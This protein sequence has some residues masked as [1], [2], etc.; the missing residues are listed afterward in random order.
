MRDTRTTPD[1][2]GG[3]SEFDETAFRADTI[4]HFPRTG[5]VDASAG[6]SVDEAPATDD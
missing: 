6:T 1:F 4:D 2:L 5:S 3:V